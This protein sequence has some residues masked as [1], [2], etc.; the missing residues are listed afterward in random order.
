MLLFVCS[1]P[2][3]GHSLAAGPSIR[4]DSDS[5]FTKVIGKRSNMS[6]YAAFT[7]ITARMTITHLS[8]CPTSTFEERHSS[9]RMFVHVYNDV[10]LRQSRIRQ[11]LQH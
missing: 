3:G 9:T 8:F 7:S 5:N 11:D 6:H 1:F 4:L 2:E 10:T